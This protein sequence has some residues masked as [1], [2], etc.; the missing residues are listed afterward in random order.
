MI[1]NNNAIRLKRQIMIRICELFYEGRLTEG[2]ELLPYELRPREND[3]TRCCIYFDR[4]IIKHRSLAVLGRHIVNE[5]RPLRL[6]DEAAESLQ[7]DNIEGDYSLEV[8]QQACAG[9]VR[10]RYFVTNAC[11][12]CLARTCM[13]NCPKNAI[14]M[15]DGKAM[16]SEKKCI[17]CG[18]CL[19][20]CPY[21]AIVYVPVPC[22]EVCPVGAID[23][24]S[25]GEQFIDP[26]K[27]IYCGKCMVACPFGAVV[28][29]SS[30]IQ[31]MKLLESDKPIIAL[32]AP[33]LVGQFKAEP[34]QLVAALGELGFAS[35]IPVTLG[36]AKTVEHEAQELSEIEEGDFMTSSCCP[37]WVETVHKHLPEFKEK[38][39]KT[40]TPMHY[41]AEYVAENFDDAV[42]VFI[43]PC[44]AKKHEAVN[45]LFVD[46]VLTFEELGSMLV[47]RDIEVENCTGQL[48]DNEIANEQ[49]FCLSGGVA[50]CVKAEIVNT[51]VNERII[52]GIDKKTVRLLKTM[53][54]IPPDENFI[55][56]M[57][58]RGGCVGGCSVV[59]YDRISKRR[60][61]ELTELAQAETESIN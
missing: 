9:C 44:I 35:A 26:G 54:K 15:N 41:T 51:E 33:A 14:E 1:V 7:S 53:T 6:K 16:V 23:R 57:S 27:C 18:K 55:E 22:E 21:H 52:N 56:V 12:G 29:K 47:A 59:S 42:R 36:A 61:Q 11:R 5:D 45:D 60:I 10:K 49:K 20:A 25:Q 24:N 46:Y 40:A 30:I 31:V 39:S 32:Y 2:I 3:S 19:S 17:N 37:A 48:I 58:C 4:E 50:E 13:M 28:E 43:S 34:S 8:L 38:V